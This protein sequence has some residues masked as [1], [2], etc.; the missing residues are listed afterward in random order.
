MR[1]TLKFTYIIFTIIL[2]L[3][4]NLSFQEPSFTIGVKRNEEFVWSCN[5]CNKLE[6]EEI[7]GNSWDDSGFF[8]NLSLNRIMKWKINSVESNA[9]SLWIN[10][11]T[12][13]WRKP[14]KWGNEDKILSIFHYLIPSDYGN[15][16]NFTSN[17]PFIPIWFP[18]PVGD[19]IGELSFSEIYDIDNRVLATINV[20]MQKSEISFN[21]PS[22]PISIIAIYNSKGILNSYKLYIEGNVVI[23]DISLVD[24]PF[25]AI[26]STIGLLSG[27]FISIGIYLYLKRK[28]KANE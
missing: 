14:N 25:Y 6:I 4:P 18:I 7:F 19:Y 10:L 3:T 23:I 24:L 20:N 12:W 28:N 15:N 17:L 27:F 2:S 21:Y 16:L 26:P 11:S 1:L 5:R 13:N 8:E 9:T 22:K